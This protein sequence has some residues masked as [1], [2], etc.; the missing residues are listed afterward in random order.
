[1]T[2]ADIDHVRAVL[3]EANQLGLAVRVRGAGHSMNGS[4]VPRPDETLLSTSGLRH[5]RF[6]EKGTVTVGAGAALWEV[7]QMLRSYGFQLLLCNDGGAPA[8]SVGGFTSAGG[9]GADTWRHG[10]FWETVAEVLL[11]TGAGEVVRSRPGDELFRW[12]FGSM[13]QLG[14]IVEV[15]VRIMGHED[16]PPAPYPAGA[17]GEVVARPAEWEHNVWHTLFVPEAAWERAEAELE[18]LARRH[19]GVWRPRSGYRYFVRFRRFNPPLLYPTQESFVAV[20]V[21]GVTA[22]E[23][24]DLNVDGL[25]A[26]DRDLATLVAAEPTL[27]RYI[28]AEL[29]F[30]RFDFAAYFGPSVFEAFREMKLACD[31]QMLL[32][33]GTVFL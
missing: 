12:I 3:H 22:T 31:P 21:W 17:T 23:H 6:D 9:I 20:G 7:D 13:G 33:R 29:T 16:G 1:V 26:L 8:A 18:A 27:R 15:K 2:I 4:S 5:F 19:A 32:G 14:F 28:Q 11:V 25:R 30:E 24:D 10:G